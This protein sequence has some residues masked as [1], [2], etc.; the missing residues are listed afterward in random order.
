M[1]G[2]GVDLQL[3]DLGARE[4]VL[5]KHPLD[6]LADHLGGTALELFAQRAASQ[7]ARVAGVAVIHLLVELVSRHVDLLGID[8]DDEVAA[9]DVRGVLGLALAAER[10]GDLRRKAPEG[11]PLGV[12]EVPTAADVAR[13]EIE[14][15]LHTKERRTEARRGGMVA[16]V[17]PRDAPARATRRTVQL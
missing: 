13:L 9:V 5:R 4:L 14:R 11:L 15:F 17:P 2:T 8:D 16:A 10:V 1:V 6:R 7:S 12:D 3:A